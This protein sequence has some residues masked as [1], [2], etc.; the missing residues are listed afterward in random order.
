ME[1]LWLKVA[2]DDFFDRCLKKKLVTFDEEDTL[3]INWRRYYEEC[4]EVETKAER[5]ARLQAVMDKI[6]DAYLSELQI[7]FPNLKVKEEW[8]RCQLW[9]AEG[10]AEL[11]RPKLA[12]LNWLVKAENYRRKTAGADGDR[13]AIV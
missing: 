13:Y 5:Q 12:L 8:Q 6:D 7:R 2:T 10:R 4:Q 11:K 1:I 3:H 9:W